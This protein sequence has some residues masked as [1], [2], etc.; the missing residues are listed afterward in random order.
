MGIR[1]EQFIKLQL[2]RKIMGSKDSSVLV[3]LPKLYYL[4]GETV[5]GK[6]RVNFDK[7]FKTKELFATLVGRIHTTITR[8]TTYYSG[9]TTVRQTTYYYSTKYITRQRIHFE[10][11]GELRGQKEYLFLFCLP[12]YIP[13][14]I[15]D[16]FGG[17]AY[18]V[19]AEAKKGKLLA[20]SQK[21]DVDL[22]VPGFIST[23]L[24][25]TAQTG[26]DIR[27]RIE[28]T[29][30]SHVTTPSGELQGEVVFSQLDEAR[31]YRN[32]RISVTINMWAKASSET[33][34]SHRDIH[35]FEIQPNEIQEGVPIK[36]KLKL[37]NLENVATFIDEQIYTHQATLKVTVNRLGHDVNMEMPIDI[38]YSSIAAA[39]VAL[40]A[41]PPVPNPKWKVALD[42]TLQLASFSSITSGELSEVEAVEIF[43]DDGKQKGKET[44]LKWE[45]V[46]PTDQPVT[47]TNKCPNCTLMVAPGTRF[48]PSCGTK[49]D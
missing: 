20:R 41:A 42:P 48:C 11:E 15:K 31:S 9:N 12:N 4:P 30:D 1:Y 3:I 16:H 19:H 35:L 21:A 44:I 46:V 39:Q 29:L 34:K 33:G 23:P 13:P 40:Q 43:E 14:S 25:G 7:A 17:I 24:K 5:F 36:F 18:T 22:H 27:P 2:G 32:V 6:V 10:G 38:G 28:M 49:L 37:P 8:E 45:P 26:P 47:S